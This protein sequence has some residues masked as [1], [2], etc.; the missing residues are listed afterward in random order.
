MDAWGWEA[1]PVGKAFSVFDACAARHEKEMK[2]SVRA[3]AKS[4]GCE[5]EP[6]PDN[7]AYA[8]CCSFGGQPGAAN[9]EYVNFVVQK[10]ISENMLPYITY[11][12][13]CRDVFLDAGK[14]AV[15]ILDLLFGTGKAPHKLATASQR[16][17]NR[18]RLKRNLL[19]RYWY[20]DMEEEKKNLNLCVR[21]SG[22]LAEKLSKNRILEEDVIEV[23]DFCERTGRRVFHP[24]QGT[25]S[26]YREIGYTTYWVEYR[27]LEQGFSNAEKNTAGGT[28][29][30]VNAY[31]HRMKIELESVWNGKKI[32]TDR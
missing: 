27:A 11:C 21:I 7:D 1:S 5:L 19:K 6:L 2:E 29:E 28:Y 10:R 22:D 14:E 13:N 8:R 3:L 20:K 15:H 4:V 32:E 30:L 18:I 26:G 31:A 16:R 23:L 17:E 25:Y 24:E 12:I 9:P